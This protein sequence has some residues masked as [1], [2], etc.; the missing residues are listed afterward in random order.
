MFKKLVLTLASY[1]L[2]ISVT[3]AENKVTLKQESVPFLVISCS[4]NP[5][6]R[7]AILAKGAF[8]YLKSHGQDVELLDL[9]DYKIPLANG[10]E[11]SAYDDPQVKVI[12]ERIAKAKGII[13]AAPIYNNSVGAVAKNLMELTTH[14]HKTILTGK[15][16]EN[17][18]VGFMGTSGG[19]G[20]RWAFMPF[21]NSLTIEAS[22]VVV[23]NFVMATGG[24]FNDKK[25]PN[26][27]TQK[28]IEE[29]SQN[30][31]RFTTALLPK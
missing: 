23:P 28:R 15:A 2:F 21:L 30:I 8:D 17:K 13:I 31:V 9:R 4:L 5:D 3:C 1:F 24:D 10:H 27:E 7:S 14:A 12:H 26:E 22:V 18:V 6:S 16:W 29:L 20:S 25:Q 11:Q 19:P